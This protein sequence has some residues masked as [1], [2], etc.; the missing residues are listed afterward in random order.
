MRSVNVGRSRLPHQPGIVATGNRANEGL[1]RRGSRTTKMTTRARLALGLLLAAPVLAFADPALADDQPDG[2]WQIKLLATAVIPDGKISQ[3]RSIDPSLASMAAFSAPQT[4]AS[5]TVTPTV[6]VEY[7]LTRT[8]SVETI[9]G[10]TAHHV[11]GSGSLNGTNL[12][13]HVLIIPATVT[14]KYHLPLGPIRP[15]VGVGPSLY[16]VMGERPGDTSTALGVTKV[17]MSSNLGIAAQAGVDIPIGKTGYGLSLDAKKY[18]VDTTANF[19]AGS[20][21]VLSTQHKLDPWVLSA[22]VSYRF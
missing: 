12:V 20:A 5:N 3:V 15:Y 16:L 1:A 21:N 19:Y 6:A 7:F 17:S 4:Y 14:V 11:D 9:A 13:N 18:W 22:G 8:I 2:K 10:I